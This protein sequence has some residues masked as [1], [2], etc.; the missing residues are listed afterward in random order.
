MHWL[1]R[2]TRLQRSNPSRISQPKISP[3]TTWKLQPLKK[4]QTKKHFLVLMSTRWTMS[5]PTWI[6]RWIAQSLFYS[7]QPCNDFLT[8]CAFQAIVETLASEEDIDKLHAVLAALNGGDLT[9]FS[10]NIGS[11]LL[12]N[13]S[14]RCPNSFR[15]T[16][17]SSAS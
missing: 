8:R 9:S 13:A 3:G 17:S 16:S 7:I 11:E 5:P 12:Q 6:K 4:P 10:K 15:F 2:N 14:T 1:F